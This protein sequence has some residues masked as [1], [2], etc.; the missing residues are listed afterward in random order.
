MLEPLLQLRGEWRQAAAISVPAAAGEIAELLD[1][2]IDVLDANN[3]LDEESLVMAADMVCKAVPARPDVIAILRMRL[4]R[5]AHDFAMVIAVEEGGNDDR[6]SGAAFESEEALAAAL[7]A[8]VGAEAPAEVAPAAA[9]ATLRPRIDSKA[10]QKS[11]STRVPVWQRSWFR[12]TRTLIMVAILGGGAVYFAKHPPELLQ[13]NVV[14][15]DPPPVAGTPGATPGPSQPPN[16]RNGTFS[17]SK[18]D[19]TGGSSSPKGDSCSWPIAITAAGSFRVAVRWDDP[20][21]LTVELVDGSGSPVSPP[22]VG[23]AG[24][25][26]VALEIPAVAAG[27]YRFRVTN[28]S[29]S[30]ATIHFS[31]TINGT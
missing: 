26:K 8:G 16:Q 29:G 7:F 19:C 15:T 3:Q 22:A 24:D 11:L 18:A 31:A 2:A 9:P 25:G 28:S 5:A 1:K 10:L 21:P 17:P 30:A 20:A 4:V 6:G 12:W 23:K 27:S 14:I 13:S